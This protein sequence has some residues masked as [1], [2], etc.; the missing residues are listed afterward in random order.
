MDQKLKKICRLL[1]SPDNMR[2]CGAA[3]VLAEL[4]PQDPEVVKALGEALENANERLTV[5]LLD[6]LTAIGSSDAAPYV[7]F[8]LNAPDVAAQLRAAAII[9]K[10]GAAVVPHVK[11][12]LERAKSSEKLVL[13]DILARIHTARTFRVILDLL[14]DSDFGLVKETCEAVRRHIGDAGPK[15]RLALHRQVVELAKSPRAKGRERVL[16]SCLLLFGA[17]GRPEAR[18]ILLKHTSPAMSPYVRRHALIGLKDLE[19]S[20]AAAKAVARKVL[21]YLAESDSDIVRRAI[22]VIANLP[23]S[24]F[25]AQHWRKLL[26]SE[27]AEV[28]YFAA[29]RLVEADTPANSRLLV[30]LLDHEDSNVAE[31]AASALAGRSKAVGN[32]LDALAAAPDPESAWRL[33][34]ILKPHSDAVDKKALKK[35]VEM[36]ESDMATGKPRYEPLLYFLRNAD[37]GTA[38]AL[39]LTTG[40]KCKRAKKWDRAAACLRRLIHT[41]S[42][43]DKTNYALSVCDLKRSPKDLAPH[44][45]ARDNALRGFPALRRSG[46]ALLEGLK[47]DRVLDAA[48]LF[49][50][51]FH[52]SESESADREFGEQILEHV[53]KKW[54]KSKQ[55]KAARNKLKQARPRRS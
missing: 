45:R 52:F 7:M 55:A 10:S 11:E 20:D 32:L 23:P 49:Y 31:M 53:A 46:F 44:L 12:R 50:V 27:N 22:D 4:A 1:Y 38:E 51:G 25:T 17:I 16:A 41:P 19:C 29:R 43:D 39:L 40:M 8:L 18:P 5:Y 35:F 37:P 21:E 30:D 47:K 3:I 33:A 36:A 6:A 9:S 13:V 15:H 34:K 24:C 26:K 28:R 14:F 48:D 42:F 54:P 2:R